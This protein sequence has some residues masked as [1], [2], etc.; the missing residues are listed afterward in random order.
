MIGNWSPTIFGISIRAWAIALFLSELGLIFLLLPAD[1]LC[2]TYAQE[3]Q[4]VASQLGEDA[5]KNLE[6]KSSTWFKRLVVDT[7]ALKTCYAL[8]EHEGADN[9]DDRGFSRWFAHRLDVFWTAVKQMFFRFG[10]LRMWLPCSLAFLIPLFADAWL[11]RRIRQNQFAYSNTLIH[12]YGGMLI[13]LVLTGLLLAPLLPLPMQPLSVPLGLG[14]VG[15]S[16]WFWLANY[17]KRS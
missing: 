17:Q 4:M 16:F 13:A 1:V 3:R 12:H 14:L 6:E 7:G 2:R 5:L 11:Q 9:F 10:M 15:A 8:C